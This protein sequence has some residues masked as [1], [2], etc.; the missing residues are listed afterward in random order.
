[1]IGNREIVVALTRQGESGFLKKPDNI[2]AVGDAPGL[3]LAANRCVH[4]GEQ[5]FPALAE[6][7][8]DVDGAPPG[9]VVGTAQAVF[10]V[11]HAFPSVKQIVVAAVVVNG[12]VLAGVE[13][14]FDGGDVVVRP[15][16][17]GRRM[18]FVGVAD[19]ENVQRVLLQPAAQQSQKIVKDGCL[20]L[21]G[22]I[23]LEAQDDA[24]I[25]LAELR[26]VNQSLRDGRV[27]AQDS[28]CG[29]SQ[30]VTNGSAFAAEHLDHHNAS[31]AARM[32]ANSTAILTASIRSPV[33]AA[34]LKPCAIWF[35]LLPMR[36]SC[37][38]TSRLVSATSLR[39]GNGWPSAS[40]RRE[41]PTARRGNT[42]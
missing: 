10:D 34:R 41:V 40:A 26:P 11:G 12:D 8:A 39:R 29:I 32:A 5:I 31:I 23:Y 22:D 9:W 17:L 28:R 20:G 16:G 13:V 24:A 6:L 30:L 25:L 42:F 2:G 18:N 15:D 19:G 38:V 33:R 27:A 14:G 3:H 1:M 36:A 35:R 4:F 21:G 37:R 7:F